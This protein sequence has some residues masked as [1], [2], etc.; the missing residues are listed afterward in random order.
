MLKRK[1]VSSLKELKQKNRF[2]KYAEEK[3]FIPHSITNG[4]RNSLKQ[5][6]NA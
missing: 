2:Q 4:V 1:Y 3:E 5:G 6:K